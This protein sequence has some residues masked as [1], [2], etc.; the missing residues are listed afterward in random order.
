[1][2]VFLKPFGRGCWSF[3]FLSEQC[4][5][6]TSGQFGLYLMQFP[7]L[8]YELKDDNWCTHLG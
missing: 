6:E 4:M 3:Q 5:E 1:M 8:K 7:S 2:A